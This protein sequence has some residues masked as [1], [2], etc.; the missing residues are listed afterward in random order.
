[1]TQD[2]KQQAHL[3]AAAPELLEQCEL[4]RRMLLHEIRC[5]EKEGDNEG[6]TLKGMAL[7]ILDAVLAKARG[8]S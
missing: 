1:M 8:E 3:I 7:A 6:A 5:S 2:A 4:F